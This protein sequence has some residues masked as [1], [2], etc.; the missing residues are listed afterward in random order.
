MRTR[1]GV[2]G[3]GAL[4]AAS[5]LAGCSALPGFGSDSTLEVDIDANY[6]DLVPGSASTRATVI[7]WNPA[8]FVDVDTVDSDDRGIFGTPAGELAHLVRVGYPAE[9]SLAGDAVIAIGNYDVDGALEGFETEE[10]VETEA[11]GTIGEIDRFT[12]TS[13]ESLYAVFG[14]Q[15]E[16]A[17]AASS[18]E[19][20]TA[21]VD[22]KAGEGTRLVG[23]NDDLAAAVDTLDSTDHLE[24]TVVPDQPVD[25]QPVVELTGFAYAPDES[26]FTAV[27][28]YKTEAFATENE[29]E[30]L[31]IWRDHEAGTADVSSSVDGRIVT[32]TGMQE[33]DAA[34]SR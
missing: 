17:V 12:V 10:G 18:E 29:S 19:L 25:S 21:I 16:L 1:R 4:L 14:A 31:E 34:V 32:V 24:A 5:S 6:R 15:E 2:L 23:Q 26:E 7:A 13:G 8:D 9:S 33:T 27:A 28:V 3:G 30:L 20:L 11:A 22:A